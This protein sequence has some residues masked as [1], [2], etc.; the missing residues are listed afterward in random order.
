MKKFALHSIK[1]GIESFG[2]G[3]EKSGHRNMLTDMLV[4]R[5]PRPS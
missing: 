2:S 3:I 5:A 4:E 1:S